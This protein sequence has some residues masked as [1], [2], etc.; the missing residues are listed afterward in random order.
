MSDEANIPASVEDEESFPLPPA[1]FEFLTL[2]FKTQAEVHMGLLHLGGEEKVK[3]NAQLARHTIDMMAMLQ[4]KTRG[5]L[6]LE[7]QRL[8]ENSL[9]ELRFRFIQQFEK[10]KS[11]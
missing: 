7:E 4:E 11:T 2:S 10:A 1:S 8:L 9:T 6:T 3:P 5:N